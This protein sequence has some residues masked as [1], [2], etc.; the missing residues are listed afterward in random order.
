MC[1]LFGLSTSA[2]LGSSYALD[3]FET[4]G[5][6]MHNNKSGWGIAYRQ[7]MNAI[8]ISE[9]PW[10]RTLFVV[11]SRFITSQIQG[12]TDH[13][14]HSSRKGATPIASDGGK[15]VKIESYQWKTH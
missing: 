9:W 3:A 10:I 1:E 7:N 14:C 5:G 8:L 15:V 13:G 11:C 12:N 6:L 4:R 2:Q